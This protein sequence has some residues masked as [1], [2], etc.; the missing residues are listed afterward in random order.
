MGDCQPGVPVEHR[1]RQVRTQGWAPSGGP[2]C[3]SVQTWS[4]AKLEKLRSQATLNAQSEGRGQSTARRVPAPRREDRRSGEELTA[5]GR[6]WGRR[7]GRGRCFR[8][9][10]WP[11][12]STGAGTD[13]VQGG[14]R[15]PLPGP[16]TGPWEGG[17]PR[18]QD[19]FLPLL[20]DGGIRAQGKQQVVGTDLAFQEHLGVGGGLSPAGVCVA[21]PTAASNRQTSRCILSFICMDA[22]PIVSPWTDTFLGSF[23]PYISMKPVLKYILGGGGV[24]WF[25]P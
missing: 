25:Y 8:E 22:L 15:A 12:Q 20:E 19:A 21:R 13:P 24:D 10:S 9:C 11:A 18:A 7:G 5:A 1:G 3:V 14:E 17:S 2:T 16:E 6:V 23:P 4:H